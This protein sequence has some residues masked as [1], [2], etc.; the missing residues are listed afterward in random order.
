MIFFTKVDFSIHEECLNQPLALS[1]MSL[2]ETGQLFVCSACEGIRDLARHFPGIRMKLFQL[3]RDLFSNVWICD[4]SIANPPFHGI[5]VSWERITVRVKLSITSM[6]WCEN[7]RTDGITENLAHWLD[8][9]RQMSRLRRKKL[10]YS[11]IF[12][13]IT[14]ACLQVVAEKK[15]H[16]Q[17]G[18]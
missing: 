14:T 16:V 6:L 18:R 7:T 15:W 9:R 11:R 13:P 5:Q 17:L 8:W 2:L 3:L 4:S 10:F 1:W 12:R